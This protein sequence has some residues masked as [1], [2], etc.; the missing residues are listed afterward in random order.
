MHGL[1]QWIGGGCYLLNK[2]FFSCSERARHR[3]NEALA[4]RWQIASWAV[5]LI[6]L[7]PW[8]IIF[9]SWRNWIAAIVEAA[10]APAMLLGLVI[11]IRGINK[12]PPKW[13][14]WLA[15]ICAPI[16]FAVSITDFGGMETL[17]QWLE[18]GLVSGFLFGTILL[19][20]QHASGYL[21]YVLMHVSCGWLMHIQGYPW[22][23]AQQA[24]SLVFILDAYMT[25]QRAQATEK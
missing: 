2:I 24:A 21:L 14:N 11:A 4:R 5:Y 6:G 12:E 8:V 9:V 17:N 19:A 3:G 16:G 22:L 13:L 1:L 25:R 15:F 23:V 18:A 7:P 20:R 10:G